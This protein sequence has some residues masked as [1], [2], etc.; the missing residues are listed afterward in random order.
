MAR[1]VETNGGATVH[2]LGGCTA[3]FFYDTNYVPSVFHIF[4]GEAEKNVYD[5]AERAN[6]FG[7]DENGDKVVAG[8]DE[9]YE[10][11]ER[12]IRRYKPY[13]EI[14]REPNY[15]L[16]ATKDGNRWRITTAAKPGEDRALT[17]EL[18]PGCSRQIQKVLETFQWEQ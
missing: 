15:D 11:A 14:T 7:V 8:A 18:G 12:G 2:D 3:L 9:N 17:R 4:C 6:K 1:R 13:I 16:D 10:A 5:A